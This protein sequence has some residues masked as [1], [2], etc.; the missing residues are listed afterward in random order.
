MLR[1]AEGGGGSAHVHDRLAAGDVVR[2]RGPRN[3]FALAASPRYLF[4]AGGIGITPILPMIAAAEAAGAEWRL[5]YGGR[6]RASMAFL[7]EL[8]GYGDRVHGA[9][10]GRDG[11]LDLA[12]PCSAPPSP[13][14]SSTAAARSRCS[15]RSRQRCAAWPSGA[16]HVERFAAEAAG[17]AGARRG[18]RGRAGS[19]AG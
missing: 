7:D 8:A 4:I 11:L 10:A 6:T 1:D 2:V 19:A 3:N 13:T 15:P 12:T 14:P 18:V 9:P 5:V 16:L 17:R